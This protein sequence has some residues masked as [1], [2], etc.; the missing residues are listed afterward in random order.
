M[1]KLVSIIT[2]TYNSAS[3][4]KE[5]INSVFNQTYPNWE[6]IIV[7]DCSVDNTKILLEEFKN[8]DQRIKTIYLDTNSGPAEAR[9]MAISIARG[10]YI[11]F[12][13]SDDYWHPDKLKLQISFMQEQNIAFSFTS[14]QHISHDGKQE[15]RV[16]EVP[17]K[18]SYHKYL[19]NTIIGCLTVVI[20]VKKTGSFKMPNIR[21]SQDMALW[22]LIMKRGFTAFGL[23]IPLAKYRITEFSNTSNKIAAAIDVWRV[24]RE[25]EHLGF[26]YSCVCF[27]GYVYN[28][29]RKRI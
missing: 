1:N 26:F 20:D 27:M 3:F 4:I 24:Y 12:L 28:A 11:A 25:I 23:N 13:D 21:S 22:L 19:K 9:N 5:C 17:K 18:I 7:D 29:I 2:P 15:Y 14:Y 6:M 16:I 10:R 8:K